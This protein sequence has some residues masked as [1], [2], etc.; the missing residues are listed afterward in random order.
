[1]MCQIKELLYLII[2]W[3][4]VMSSK[5][6]VDVGGALGLYDTETSTGYLVKKDGTRWMCRC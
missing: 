3:N 5:S 4:I 2:T 1:M 6:V